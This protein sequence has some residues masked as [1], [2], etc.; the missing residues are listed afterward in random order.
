[1]IYVD[2]L[3][4]PSKAYSP[5]SPTAFKK[6]LSILVFFVRRFSLRELDFVSPRRFPLDFATKEI[7]EF[8]Y[9]WSKLEFLFPEEMFFVL[10]H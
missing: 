1:M 2:E 8:R 5:E 6:R 10:Y 7:L 3:Y 4:N 9:C